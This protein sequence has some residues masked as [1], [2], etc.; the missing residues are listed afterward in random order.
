MPNFLKEGVEVG[1]L[2]EFFEFVYSSDGPVNF[3]KYNGKTQH[4]V[5]V[6]ID[7]DKESWMFTILKNNGSTYECGLIIKILA[8]GKK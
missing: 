5:G 6:V 7:I 4:S 2:V 1:D 8:K 3:P